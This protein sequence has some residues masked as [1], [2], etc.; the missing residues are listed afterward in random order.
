M[1]MLYFKEFMFPL[2]ADSMNYRESDIGNVILFCG[3]LPIW[4]GDIL[5]EQFN[6][7]LGAKRSVLLAFS[8]YVAALVLFALF[9]TF[10]VAVIA[11]ILICIAS[12]FGFS[13]EMM[14]YSE[15]SSQ[16]RINE[17][18]SMGIYSLF[19]NLGQTLGA[20][21][22]GALLVFGFKGSAFT[23]A[24]VSAVLAI[25]FSLVSI[26]RKGDKA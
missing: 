12:A 19:D 2:F 8:L 22:F 15:L 18:T 11:V 23:V 25:I 3:M 9:E 17:G 10:L 20:P 24:A 6:K 14:Y 7:T 13:S 4:L 26:Q 21:V 16:Y 5:T 1:I